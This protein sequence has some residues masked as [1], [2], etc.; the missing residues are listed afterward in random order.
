MNRSFLLVVTISLSLT[1]FIL[2]DDNVRAVQAKLKAD[3]FYFGEVNGVSSSDLSAA[4][5]RYQIRN[6]L[7]ITG[8]LDGETSKALGFK[9]AATETA[10]EPAPT[11]E[12]WRN[13][14]KGDRQ[15]LSKI[16][17]RQSRTA[18]EATAPPVPAKTEDNST[19]VLSQERV[20]DYIGAFVLAGL[21]AQVGAELEFF[22]DR[23]RYYNE[24]L[25]GREAIRRDLLRYDAHWPQRRFWLAGD[26]KVE[27]QAD[28]RL[29]VS[30]PLRYDLRRG[31]KHSSGKIM[32]DL[33]LEVIGPDDL[34]I[35]SVNE[36]KAR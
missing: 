32:K 30:F 21:D 15:F 10:A 3:G 26:V 9:A 18:V 28:S 25:I 12:T 33:L 1:A 20:R 31:A 22:G 8:K 23:V 17:G 27:P 36:S 16:N 35:V 6:G 14:R 29:R 4:L 24:G 2:A 11:S 7:Q 13:L 5:T 34:Q 19:F